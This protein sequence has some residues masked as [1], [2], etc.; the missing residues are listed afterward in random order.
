MI[1]GLQA[2]GAT[3]AQAASG[4]ITLCI[5]Q[6]V[7]AITFS[8]R[9]R[10]PLS[11]AWSTPG[12]ALLVAAQGTTDDFSAAV[13]AFAVCGALIVLTG[14]WPA[15]TQAMTRIPRPIASAMLAGI[16]FP[17]CIAPVTAS[18]QLPALAL[19]IVV[20]WLVL[21]RLAPRWAVP[22]ALAVTVVVVALSAGPSWLD[23]A[24]LAPRLELIVPTLDPLAIVSLGVPLY[25]VTMAGQNV[26]GFAVLQ[27]F[28]YPPPP[29]SAVLIGSGA[30]TAVGA[31]F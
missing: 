8:L 14:L 17:I 11:F 12:A 30:V 4:L 5:A 20:V 2:V 24:S 3:P 13:G 7:L 23:G 16:L 21:S 19:P 29:A 31:A 1:A 9:Y 15:L 25:I 22:A 27:T 10:T 6:G 28:E 26:P 18:V